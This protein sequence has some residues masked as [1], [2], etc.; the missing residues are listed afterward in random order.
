MKRVCGSLITLCLL[1][2]SAP[3]ATTPRTPS[4]KGA[5][6]YIIHPKDGDVVRSPVV[7]RFGLKGMG[8]APAR[9][10]PIP[11]ITIC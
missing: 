7:V 4:P 3:A 2:T 9:R 1:V 8:V 11:A 6:V 5:G 10:F